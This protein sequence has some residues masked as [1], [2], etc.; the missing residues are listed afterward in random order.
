MVETNLTHLS[1][2]VP[3]L[4][5]GELDSCNLLNSTT[6]LPYPC[7]SWVYDDT[8]YKSSRA[9]EWNLVCD[10]RWKG[11]FSQAVYMFGAFIGAASLGNLADKFGRKPVFCWSAFLQLIIGVGVAFT[12]NFPFFLILRFLYG[13]FGSTG[14]YIPGFVLSMELVGPSKRSKCGVTFQV[15]FAFGFMLVAAWGSIIKDRQTLQ[16]IY[17]LHSL[18]LIGHYWLM[19]ESP[20]W[21]WSKG[22]VSEAIAIIEKALRINKNPITLEK[23]RFLCQESESKD[24]KNPA[25]ILDLF[26]TPRLRL[27][28]LNVCLCWSANALVYYGLSLNTGKLN[29][30]PFLLLFLMGLVEIPSY[31][32][33]VY[34]M[35]CMGR[36]FLTA[37]NMILGGI[38]CIIATNLLMGSIESISFV[39]L[40][41]F[42]ITSSFAVIFNYSAELFPTVVRNSGMG[43]GAMCARIAG[44]FTPLVTLLDSFEPALPSMIFAVISILSGFWILFLPETLKNPMPESLEDGENFGKGDTFLT[45][46]FGKRDLGNS[47]ELEEI[48]RIEASDQAE[49]IDF[50]K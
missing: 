42:L 10:Q 14:C 25:G 50:A 18:V 35:D 21:L 3:L 22:R 29:G 8:Y 1:Q 45:S 43:L 17:G 13:I 27:K 40:G 7:T 48:E 5:S 38:C 12:S 49:Q 30:N 31:L 32:V 26:K 36:R 6:G 16:V 28:T 39:M 11:A 47:E 2:Y 23:T 15:A 44:A 37:I 19:D 33:T 34:L 41:K 24:N 20:R 46:C 9:I 4:P